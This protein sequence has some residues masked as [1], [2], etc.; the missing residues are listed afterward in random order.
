M[1][2]VRH[3]SGPPVDRAPPLHQLL[4]DE[5]APQRG[6]VRMTAAD[7][8][9]HLRLGIAP[10]R[11]KVL[12]EPAQHDEPLLPLGWNAEEATAGIDE[13]RKNAIVIGRFLNTHSR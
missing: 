6:E 3:A 10:A 2:E 9:V 8:S 1:P 13:I 4:I 5:Q 7:D 12:G 11:L